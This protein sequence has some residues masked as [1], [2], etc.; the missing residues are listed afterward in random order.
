MWCYR[1]ILNISWIDKVSNLE[2][3]RR[4]NKNVE[5]LKTIKTRKLEYFGHMIRGEK[6]TLLQL[7]LQGK[8]CGKRGRGR[9]R[10]SWLQNLREWYDYNS[11]QLFNAARNKHH[12]AIM[13]SDLHYDF[14]PPIGAQHE[15]EEVGYQSSRASSTHVFTKKKKLQLCNEAQIRPKTGVPI[16]SKTESTD[17]TTSTQHVRPV[18]T[19]LS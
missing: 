6:Y 14:R 13:I 3:L 15:E 9:K 4:M 5:V 10:T 2:V 12:L 11:C 7:I 8:I 19:I 16:T 18:L 17:R 1:R